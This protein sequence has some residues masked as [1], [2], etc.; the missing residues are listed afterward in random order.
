M[1]ICVYTY[2]YASIYACMCVY[3]YVYVCIARGTVVT[4]NKIKKEL[5]RN[6]HISESSDNVV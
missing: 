1:H 6:Y 5:V 3:I 2:I 4:E